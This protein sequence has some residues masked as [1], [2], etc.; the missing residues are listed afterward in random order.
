M[1]T[2]SRARAAKAALTAVIAPHEVPY[3]IWT[4]EVEPGRFT[5]IARFEAAPDELLAADL[6][7]AGFST[8]YPVEEGPAEEAETEEAP[9]EETQPEEA[10]TE[11]EVIA[12]M[13]EAISPLPKRKSGYINE[14]SKF[15]GACAAV[16]A[17]ADSMV[18][19]DGKVVRKDV[20]AACRAQGI[21]Y[22]TARTQYQ[23][24]YSN[25]FNPQA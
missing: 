5:A 9:V 8:Y 7:A 17:I 1:K 13:E 22:G 10:A 16:W 14:I 2:Y 20:I 15:G 18:G 25:R 24:W 12:A 4:E 23:R 19:P 3:E 21:A 6:A 11:E